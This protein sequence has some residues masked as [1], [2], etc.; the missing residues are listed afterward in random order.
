MS[1]VQILLPQSV[2]VNFDHVT[3]FKCPVF[4]FAGKDDEATP[5]SIVRDYFGRIRAPEK[6]LFM[7]DRAA[8]YVVNERPGVVLMDLVHDVRPLTQPHRN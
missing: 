6:K 5:S 3:T 7:I 2:D 1:S 8:H 4:F